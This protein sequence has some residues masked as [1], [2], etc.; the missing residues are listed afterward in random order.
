[1]NVIALS[2]W[3]KCGDAID[4]VRRLL[5]RYFDP[6]EPYSIPGYLKL[7]R[8]LLELYRCEKLLR[9]G[10]REAGKN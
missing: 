6:L 4:V 2:W 3:A 10:E 5:P 9:L 8:S 1:M 7:A